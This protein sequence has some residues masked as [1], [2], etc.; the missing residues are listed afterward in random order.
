MVMGAVTQFCMMAGLARTP[1][2][3]SSVITEVAGR[4][5]VPSIVNGFIAWLIWRFAR[6]AGDDWFVPRVT[7]VTVARLCLVA[8]LVAG[9]VEV[10]KLVA[11]ILMGTI[12]R[13]EKGLTPTIGSSVRVAGRAGVA[14]IIGHCWILRRLGCLGDR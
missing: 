8:G 13:S 1:N 9:E 2:I 12:R 4:A 10:F 14:S 3:G 6:V 5:G 7:G 11:G